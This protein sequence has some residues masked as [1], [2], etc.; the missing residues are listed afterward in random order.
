MEGVAGVVDFE[1]QFLIGRLKTI[2]SSA[3]SLYKK[4]G[5]KG[6]EAIPPYGRPPK[7]NL[8]D[9]RNC[10]RRCLRML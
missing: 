6:I 1:F 2:H 5:R 4:K 8:K 9:R 7:L 10:K 3:N